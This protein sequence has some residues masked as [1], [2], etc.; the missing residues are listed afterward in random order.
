MTFTSYALRPAL[1]CF[2]LTDRW[3]FLVLRKE[4]SSVSKVQLESAVN[5]QQQEMKQETEYDDFHNLIREARR[6][7]KS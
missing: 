5:Q 7:R 4:C 6:N 2:L 3:V 1:F